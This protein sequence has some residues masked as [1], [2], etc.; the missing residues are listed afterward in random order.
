MPKAGIWIAILVALLGSAYWVGRMD[1][2][3]L[4]GQKAVDSLGGLLQQQTAIDRENQTILLRQNEKKRQQD[5]VSEA[6]KHARKNSNKIAFTHITRGDVRLLNAS[7]SNQRPE[8]IHPRLSAAEKRAASTVT[9]QT[10][11]TADIECAKSYNE[12]ATKR[13]TLIDIVNV[14][15]EKTNEIV[16]K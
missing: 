10:L 11:I 8:A 1:C 16:C 2:T 12:C 13:N 3:Y 6:I 15:M 14:Y 4:Y 7:R 9:E 5:A